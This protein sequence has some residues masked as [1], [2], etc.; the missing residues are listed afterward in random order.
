MSCPECYKGF[1]LPGEPK[2]TMFGL[3]YFAA[4]PK[5]ATQR[6]KAICLLTDIFGSSLPNPKIVADYLAEHVGVD[7]WVPDFFLG[8]PIFK[9]N[10]LNELEP[11]MPDRAGV[12]TSWLTIGRFIIK[13]LPHLPRFIANRPSVVDPRV[14]EFI[15]RIKEEKGYER[16]GA[17]GYCF[18]GAIAARL[19]ATDSVNTIV[20]A[21]PAKLTPEQMRAIKV[22]TSWALAQEDHSFKDKDV[23]TAQDIFKEKEEKSDHVDYEFRI[24]E[25]TA[26]GFAVRPNLKVPEVKAG[27]EGALEQTVVWFNKTL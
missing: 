20:V 24:W 7:V 19:G 27:Y 17:V 5:D 14:Q 16:I 21:H 23:K 6:R 26:H 25:G 22:P 1:V 4:A 13:G 3:D 9:V 12:K 10:D 11:L 2:G 18:G 8:K 15:K